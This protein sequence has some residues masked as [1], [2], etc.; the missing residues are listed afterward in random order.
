MLSNFS[1]QLSDEY[2]EHHI[3]EELEEM[4]T[5]MRACRNVLI[6]FSLQEQER[7]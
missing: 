2:K 1:L 6:I 7:S 4:K 5:C 3:F